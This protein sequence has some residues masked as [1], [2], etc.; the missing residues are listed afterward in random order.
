[1]M[2]YATRSPS[3]AT[4]IVSTF[5]LSQITDHKIKYCT[6]VFGL[7]W[8]TFVTGLVMFSSIAWGSK[9]HQWSDEIPC[10]KPL[11]VMTY[12]DAY[13]S[14]FILFEWTIIA[15]CLL[16][17]LQYFI[18]SSPLPSFYSNKLKANI[19]GAKHK[20]K[21]ETKDMIKNRDTAIS[22]T[23][24][25][26][27]R[28][29]FIYEYAMSSQWSLFTVFALFAALYHSLS[30][31]LQLDAIFTSCTHPASLSDS[32]TFITYHLSR[33]FG[34]TLPGM[35]FM[36]FWAAKS[37]YDPVEF[38]IKRFE[39]KVLYKQLKRAKQSQLSIDRHRLRSASSAT[40]S[41]C[42]AAQFLYRDNT[43]TLAAVHSV[44]SRRSIKVWLFFATTFSLYFY[45]SQS[46]LDTHFPQCSWRDSDA[47][48]QHGDVLFVLQFN[49]LRPF[50]GMAFMY[51]LFLM[52]KGGNPGKR[53]G[54]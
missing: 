3:Q 42:F 6:L 41:N 29:A 34:D 24:Y 1:M 2:S 28:C 31:L 8:L 54:F 43:K 50:V 9:T 13:F 19:P 16:F 33:L 20:H 10:L 14:I 27:S 45:L 26:Q 35:A 32:I 11:I 44:L 36:I 37:V 39:K 21:I 17:L 23:K 53:G 25:E 46:A 4:S 51:T 52:L 5:S 40:T 48:A 38:Q 49:V 12:R 30:A 47:F 22:R 7:L 18:L 15:I